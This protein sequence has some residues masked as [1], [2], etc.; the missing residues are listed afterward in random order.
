MTIAENSRRAREGSCSKT[1]LDYANTGRSFKSLERDFWA[2][3]WSKLLEGLVCFTFSTAF[4][5]EIFTSKETRCLLE[6]CR[7]FCWIEKAFC[8]RLPWTFWA[9]LCCTSISK[10]AHLEKWRD[11]L[12]SFIG[13]GMYFVKLVTPDNTLLN[14][15]LHLLTEKVP[16]IKVWNIGQIPMSYIL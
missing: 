1:Y 4:L 7:L 3:G 2:F 8:H 10:E 12:R 9:N 15:T 14:K 11:V 13:L 5:T 16:Y 6:I